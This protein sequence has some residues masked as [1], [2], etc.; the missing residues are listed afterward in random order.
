MYH[1]LDILIKKKHILYLN[2]IRLRIY[3]SK[4]P[5]DII[6]ILKIYVILMGIIVV[7]KYLLF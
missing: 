3:Y 4:K 7:M 5:K 6:K 2:Y 1:Y